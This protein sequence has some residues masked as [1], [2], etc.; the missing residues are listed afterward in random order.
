MKILRIGIPLL[1]AFSVFAFASV[2]PW[3]QSFLEIGAVLLLLIWAAWHAFGD[4]GQLYWNPLGWPLLA[5]AV[6]GLLQYFLGL[7]VF[8]FA[9]KV[10]LLK[11]AAY[12]V[13]FFLAGQAFRTAAHRLAWAWFLLSLGF[14]VSLFGILQHFTFNGKLYWLRQLRFIGYPFGPFTNRDHFAG[15]IEL[16]IPVGLAMLALRGTRRD[17]IPLV[18][19]FTIVP[20]GAVFLSASRA[21]ITTTCV[22]LL[23]LAIFLRKRPV[24]IAR[25]LAVVAI[26][27]AAGAFVAWLGV[28]TALERFATLKS[29]AVTEQRRWTMI[30]DSWHIFVAH[31]LMGSG[32]GTLETAY[33]RYASYYDGLVVNH[34]H[35][36]YVEALVETGVLGVTCCAV[37]LIGLFRRSLAEIGS[38]RDQYGRAVRIGCLVACTGLLIHGL[39]DFN[40]HIPSNALLFFLQAQIASSASSLAPQ[41]TD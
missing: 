18:A 5:I 33:P 2:E 36:D 6:L 22:Q 9:T 19:L 23:L 32:L 37:F 10:E 39:V 12:L 14:T 41:I 11:L 8:P 34:A 40:L 15:F 26:L 3:A 25:M 20:I 35:N 4:D 16:I 21:G 1:V 31:P 17:Q 27:L 29:G 7:T 24:G 38:D 30:H 28:G 13:L